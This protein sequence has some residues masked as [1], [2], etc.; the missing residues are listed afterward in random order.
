MFDL[1]KKNKIH[2]MFFAQLFNGVHVTGGRVFIIIYIFEQ[3][4]KC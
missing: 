4:M 3:K 2:L 1:I